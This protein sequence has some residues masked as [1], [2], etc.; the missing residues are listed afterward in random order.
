MTLQASVRTLNWTLGDL[1]RATGYE[2]T[3]GERLSVGGICEDSREVRPGDLFVAMRGTRHDG[4]AYARAALQRG[5][6]AVAAERD[7]GPA[8]RWLKVGDARAAVGR[9]AD[10]F[11][12]DPSRL[13]TLI[14]VTGTNGKTTTAHLIGQ[15]L[16]GPIGI[17]GTF[18]VSYAGFAA[19]SGNTTPSATAMRRHL[20]AMQRANCTACVAEVSSHA[21]DQGRVTGLRFAAGVYTNLS[22]DHL[23][24]HGTMEAYAAAKA[25]LFQ[26]LDEDAVAVLNAADP[27][28]AA[29]STRARVT[30]FLVENVTVEASGTR[31][32]WRNREVRLRIVGRHNAENAAA[33]L[34]T[35]H[36]L[37]A[38][39]VETVQLIERA[40]PAPGRLE[41]IQRRPFLV[42]VD[43]AHTDDG[44][45]SALR[46]VREVTE[47]SVL[48][49]FGCGGDRDRTKRPRMGRVASRC[50]DQVIV[51]NDNP[52]SEDPEAIAREIVAGMERC[53]PSVILDRKTAIEEA[54][55]RAQPGDTV[56]IAG[57]G[58]ETIQIVEEKQLPFDD[59][60]VA[61]DALDIGYE[62]T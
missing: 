50:A 58:H 17:I 48:L 11:Y 4:L 47:G 24:Y 60:Q 2:L 10:A 37:G 62:L 18:G 14:G 13:L 29:I 57:K 16:P 15:L 8:A 6:V 35:A 7:P 42:L 55:G 31:F 46:A 27:A 26:Q 1:A 53:R 12:G 25:S 36:A 59:A 43:Y 61:R 32:F 3:A 40:L 23:D 49:V 9:L 41:P 19:E 20:R 56:L 5:A 34:E 33:A 44:L 28:C 54:I 45:D 52:R 22:G 39:P 51:T 21:L 30:R 38:D